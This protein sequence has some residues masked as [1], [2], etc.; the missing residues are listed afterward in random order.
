M[1]L[2]G[3]LLLGATIVLVI[4]YMDNTVRS[5]EH[6]E[7]FLRLHLL[8]YVPHT[9]SAGPASVKEAYHTLRTGLLFANRDK[10]SKTVLI[11]SAGPGEGKTSTSLNLAQIL[12]S[13]G[14]RVVLIDCDLRRPSVH[15][16]LGIPKEVGLTEYLAG[17]G[18]LDGYLKA[19]AVPTLKVITSGPIPP[20]PPE[21]FDT[22]RFQDLL[23]RLK[24]SFDWVLVDSP[25]VLSVT[26]GVIL[27]AVADGVI[28]VVQHARY[29]REMV[30]RAV[31]QLRN[32]NATL[33]GC[34]LNN[35]RVTRDAYYYSYYYSYDYSGERQRKRGRGDDGEGPDGPA[36]GE[37]PAT[38]EARA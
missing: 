5:P 16:Y 7:Q 23:P 10:T 9:D 18:E 28:L 3:G 36:V 14:D 6:V 15:K 38:V 30:R 33:L 35:V 20:N 22:E 34:V 26:D 31:N 19:T 24:A 25:P 1:G 11:T 29:A 17:R 4:D 21:M 32:V 27:S 13:S 8:T 37:P 2:L 12:A